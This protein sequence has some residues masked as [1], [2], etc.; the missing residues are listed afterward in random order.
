MLCPRQEKNTS[1]LKSAK[2]IS[3][4][5]VV[6]EREPLKMRKAVGKKPVVASHKLIGQRKFI[7]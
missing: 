1:L 4:F 5:S 2:T 6:K 7:V 3:N